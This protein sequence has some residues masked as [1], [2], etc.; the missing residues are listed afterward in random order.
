MKATIMKTKKTLFLTLL[1]MPS[2]IM[3]SLAPKPVLAKDQKS[4]AEN[5]INAQQVKP[6]VPYEQL[7]AI[8][9]K[10]IDQKGEPSKQLSNY[11]LPEL[12]HLINE[13]SK[14]EPSLNSVTIEGRHH[15]N[16]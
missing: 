14:E 10:K 11:F 15:M 6:F 3:A 5:K 9:K 13:Y 1:L 16:Y 12:V 7:D 8:T 2:C 4:Q